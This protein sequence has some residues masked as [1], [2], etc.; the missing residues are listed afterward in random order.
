LTTVGYGDIYPITV[1]GRI[2]TAVVLFVGLGVVAIP[3]GMDATALVKA[4]TIEEDRESPDP[5]ADGNGHISID[6]CRSLEMRA[7]LSVQK[8]QDF[9]AIECPAGG[10]QQPVTKGPMHRRDKF[11]SLPGAVEQHQR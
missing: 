11:Q 1:G 6:L 9:L 8:G 5:S 7:Q 10:H 4:K 2:F 3:A